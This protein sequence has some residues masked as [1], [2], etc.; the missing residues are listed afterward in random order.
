[1]RL[2]R[3]ERLEK[4]ADALTYPAYGFDSPEESWLDDLIRVEQ[5]KKE[6]A[7]ERLQ[8]MRLPVMRRQPKKYS[9]V[10]RMKGEESVAI[11]RNAQKQSTFFIVLG[12]V[13]RRPLVRY[14][15]WKKEHKVRKKD[16]RA[17]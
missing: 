10:T 5:L 7:R 12:K 8:A 13:V 17:K 16:L 4:I 15:A 6:T 2:S 11:S 3:R 9:K 14:V 1:M